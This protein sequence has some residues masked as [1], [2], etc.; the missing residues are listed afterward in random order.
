MS[1]RNAP[2]NLSPI[3]RNTDP[4]ARR[5]TSKRAL[6]LIN[7]SRARAAFLLVTLLA[8]G[9]GAS[10]N[11]AGPRAGIVTAFT[12]TA[13]TFAS[14]DC[15][16]PKSEWD[17]GQ[18][19]CAGVTGAGGSRRI[20]WIAPDGEVA[21]VSDQ[22]TGAGSD[23]YT[24]LTTGPFAQYGTWKVVSIDSAGNGFSGAAFLVRPE[25]VASADLVI[26]KF[27]PLRA[28]A[29][30]G[31]SYD[32]EIINRGPDA[33]LN[34]VLSEPVPND[35]TFASEVQTSSLPGVVC[36]GPNPGE[37]GTTTCTIPSLA[38]NQPATFTFVF[39]VNSGT[40]VG[41]LISNTATVLSSTN[42]LF[43]GDNFANAQTNVVAGTPA[44]ACTIVCPGDITVDNNPSDPNPCVKSVTY[45]TPT[46]SG[47]CADPD[48]GQIPTVVCSPPS[49]SDFPVG[50][51]SVICSTG[52]TTCSF[53]ITVS[54]TRAPVQPSIVCPSDVTASESSPGSGSARVNYPAPTTTGNC[55]SVVCNPPSGAS[56]ALGT[57]PVTCNG[58]DA[59]NN[60]IS[61]SFS[62]TVN[63]SSCGL[64]CPDD[65]TVNESSPGSGSATVT[66]ATPT[67]VGSCPSVTIVCNPP[68][69]SSFPVG[70]TQVD[71]SA[72][73]Q[74]SNVLA[75][76]SFTVRVNSSSTC[77]I[78]C[79]ANVTATENPSG[80]GSAT[81]TYSSP[82]STGT[83]A[84]PPVSCSPPSGSSFPIGSTTVN[85]SRSDPA[86]NVSTCSFTVTVTGGTPCTITCPSNVTQSSGGCGTAVT[87][88]SPTTSGS[89]GDPNNPDDPNPW[90]CNPPSGSF[91]PVGTSTVVC[92]TDV[93]VSCSF[94]VT[95]TGTDTIPPVI[96]SCAAATFASADNCQGV[97]PNV[98]SGVDASDD[99]TPAGL[100]TVTQSPAPGTIVGTG[101]TTIIVTV[102][103]ASN[104]SA[105][106]S[107]TFTVVEPIPPTITC[108]SSI[109]QCSSTVNYTAPSASDNCPG[110]VVVCSPASGS[111]FPS[112]STLVTCTATDLSNNSSS[113]SFTVTVTNQLTDLGAGQ[114]WVGLK[115][116]DDVGTKFDFLAQVSKNGS[117]I[118][119]GQINDQLGGS[120][121][122]NNAI[123]RTIDLALSSGPK[124]LCPGDTLSFTLSVRVAASS[125]HV[126][127]TARLWFNDSA[128][129]S[130]FDATIGGATNVY[131]LQSGS[132]LGTAAGPGPKKTIDVLVNRNQGG[133][134]FKPF[135]TWSKTF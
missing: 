2:R 128:A 33:A 26:R 127:G 46:P 82:T 17:L 91:F 30:G 50:S 98:T 119:S 3:R 38:P 109:S 58:T 96:N 52:T 14:S 36:G 113:C 35:S 120:S 67:T 31:I 51:S 34:V 121:G 122:F 18:T 74:S 88:P 21:D 133:N 124:D 85:C 117:L 24:L 39:N 8:L 49:G 73:D 19:A 129:N 41:T 11:G 23:T 90:S 47:G 110:V 93:G 134:P 43:Q 7:P 87:Y 29:G 48:S 84:T 5:G 55:V 42:E 115:N 45:A 62:V 102:K 75:T 89:C 78:T 72:T 135:G 126:S 68:S 79:P 56:F 63:A 100:L 57:T 53:T 99:C 103:D 1:G 116:S 101:T 6:A 54:E 10:L 112:G 32:I 65:K 59:A 37:T 44:P 92:S 28:I 95:V 97:V 132:A 70:T 105:T 125:G 20:V 4:Q 81:V 131:F 16:T 111:I 83:C 86:G 66:Y 69:G 104:N 12:E 130:R 94:T 25:N 60:T 108:P 64:D 27:G 61:C 71:C 123:L 76:C 107:T 13:A 80:S 118:G 22:F 15:A 40:P 9:F 77:A 106:C 114:V